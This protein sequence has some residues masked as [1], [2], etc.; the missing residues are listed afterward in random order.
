MIITG[1]IRAK[2]KAL[3]FSNTPK[4]CNGIISGELKQLF[5][6]CNSNLLE[7]QF[8]EIELEN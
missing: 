2:I 1:N 4:S 3:Q 5:G 8:C 6:V 7:N